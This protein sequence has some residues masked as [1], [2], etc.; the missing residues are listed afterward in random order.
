MC[1]TCPHCLQRIR[2]IPPD[3]LRVLEEFGRKPETGLG[4]FLNF[5]NRVVHDYKDECTLEQWQVRIRGELH[6]GRNTGQIEKSPRPLP[7]AGLGEIAPLALEGGA[8]VTREELLAVKAEQLEELEA[9][10]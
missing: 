4:A 5:A 2:G 3:E 10:N 6:R 9:A 7:R 8:L 1:D